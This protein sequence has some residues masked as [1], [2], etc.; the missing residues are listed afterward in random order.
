MMRT[1][2]LE[3]KTDI[4]CIQ[5]SH[6]ALKSRHRS[7]CPFIGSDI[8]RRWNPRTTPITPNRNRSRDT[9]RKARHSLFE[10]FIGAAPLDIEAKDRRNHIQLG[11]PCLYTR[12][13]DFINGIQSTLRPKIKAIKPGSGCKLGE[14][15][16][17]K[18]GCAKAGATKGCPHLLPTC[19]EQTNRSWY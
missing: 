15:K 10:L 5:D 17:R 2:K 1:N 8:T 9:L 13:A 12:K 7:R 4:M 6:D 18:T 14:I 3:S 19:K 16:E 11:K